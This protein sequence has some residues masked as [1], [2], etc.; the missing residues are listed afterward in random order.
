MLPQSVVGR[1]IGSVCALTGTIII[2]L[3]VPIISENFKIFYKEEKTRRL[4]TERRNALE[5]AYG[6]GVLLG[7]DKEQEDQAARIIQKM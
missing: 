3:P 1:I 6:R 5:V 4:V 2:A 7:H